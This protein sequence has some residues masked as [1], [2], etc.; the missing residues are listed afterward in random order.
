[1]SEALPTG[2]LLLTQNT[3][4]GRSIEAVGVGALTRQSAVAMA[5]GVL[6]QGLKFLVYLYIARAFSSSDFG[7]VA[8]ANAI[9]AFIFVISQFGFPVFGSRSVARSG[10]VEPGLLFAVACCRAGLAVLGTV[11]ALGFLAVTPGATTRDYALVA[12]FGLSNVPLAGLFD[13]AFQGLSRQG[14]SATLNV[15]WQFFW[16]A[17]TH[18]GARTWTNILVVPIAL[19]AAGSVASLTGLVWL[20]FSRVM[21]S[22]NSDASG[23]SAQIWQ[24]LRTGRS[25][26][27]G[28]IL[29]NI[30]IWT[31]TIIVRLLLGEQA[32][33]WYAAGN[34]V[35]MAVSMLSNFYMQAAFPLLC[36]TSGTNLAAFRNHFQR[37]YNELMLMFLPGSIWGMFYAPTVILFLFKR[38]EYLAGIPVF[39]IFQVV[40]PLIVIN[41]LYGMGILL[42]FHEDRA[43]RRAL[44]V[45]VGV[46]VVL[47]P[48]LTRLWGI[49]GAAVATLTAYAVSIA[50]FH[51]QTRHLIQPKHAEA[52]LVPVLGGLTAALI[53]KLLHTE[54]FFALMLLALAY[55]I[56]FLW[57]RRRL[58]EDGTT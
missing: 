19:C 49:Q 27:T 10:R 46:L 2:K 20:H 18:I 40:L 55:V 21:E 33:G 43:Y 8:F 7:S 22:A 26:G 11:G 45:A 3:V 42:A 24:T 57:H 31:D 50:L 25:L 51:I 23:D 47:C 1:M 44:A 38:Q 56:L 5:G 6:S 13:W 39:R 32:V 58:E 53:G 37:A 35:A 52:L 14:A 9:N 30:L 34:R 4:P 15:I 28:T 12:C 48:V 29:L 17:F 36:S 16:L 54:L 41:L